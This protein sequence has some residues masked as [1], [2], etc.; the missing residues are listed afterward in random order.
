MFS[1]HF[2]THTLCSRGVATDG[3]INLI[4]SWQSYCLSMEFGR[5]AVKHEPCTREIIQM[6]VIAGV[7]A[8]VSF[9][10]LTVHSREIQEGTGDRSE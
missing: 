9:L 2:Q 7:Y 3:H 4:F 10:S 5:P 8:F 6:F 1:Y